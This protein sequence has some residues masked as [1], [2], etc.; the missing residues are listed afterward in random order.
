M[1]DDQRELLLEARDS[2]AAAKLLLESEF[3]GYAA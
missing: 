2:T 1:T 3:P